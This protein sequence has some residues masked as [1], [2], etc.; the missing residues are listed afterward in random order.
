MPIQ[1]G[2]IHTV[3]CLTFYMFSAPGRYLVYERMGR[4]HWKIWKDTC[5]LESNS[6]K[7]QPVSERNFFFE[8]NCTQPLKFI[9]N[10][11][12]YAEILPNK[13]HKSYLWSTNGLQLNAWINNEKY[14]PCHGPSYKKD[15]LSWN[16]HSE[17]DTMSSFTTRGKNQG[18]KKWSSMVVVLPGR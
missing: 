5:V 18:S 17:D 7:W 2:I 13:W 15:T 8:H 11:S 12:A 14:Q 3:G 1:A 10:L 6:W 4:C 16:E 9:R